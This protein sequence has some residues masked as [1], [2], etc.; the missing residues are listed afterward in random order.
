MVT[1]KRI[2]AI[3]MVRLLCVITINCDLD[4]IS[5]TISLKRW[6][7]ASSNGASTS[8]RTQKGDGLIRKIAKIRAMAVRAFSPPDNKPTFCKRLPG[9]CTTISMPVSSR[10]CSSVRG[11][12]CTP[13]QKKSW[14]NFLEHGIDLI[15]SLPKPFTGGSVD[16]GDSGLQPFQ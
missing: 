2:S 8:S 16:L 15:E 9:G 6:I 11:Q 10:S 4:D 3:S 1:P 14:E 5:R 13:A 12:F 7:L